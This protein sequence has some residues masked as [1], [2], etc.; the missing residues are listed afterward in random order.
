MA[1]RLSKKPAGKV[2]RKES[3]GRKTAKKT[4]ESKTVKGVENLYTLTVYIIGGPIS[5][6]YEGKVTARTIQIKGSQTLQDLHYAIFDAFDR[7]EEHLYEF[8][9][10]SGPYDR[11]K[12]YSM[13]MPPDESEFRGHLILLTPRVSGSPGP[14]DTLGVAHNL[15]TTLAALQR[16]PVL[17]GPGCSRL[18]HLFPPLP[19]YH[20]QEIALLA[21]GIKLNATGSIVGKSKRCASLRGGHFH[22][23]TALRIGHP[24]ENR[25]RIRFRVHRLRSVH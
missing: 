22:N 10:G 18:D 20:F 3:T 13:R 15:K 17:A 6:E 25:F 1:N 21:V 24:K 14:L 5:E 9:L 19:A 23:R 16:A 2:K 11:S 8:N 7:W 12:I 4:S